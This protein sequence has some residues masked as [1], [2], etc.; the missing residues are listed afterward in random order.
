M[1][2]LLL[3]ALLTGPVSAGDA[4]VAI[5]LL[6]TQGD[7]VSAASAARLDAGLAAALEDLPAFRRVDPGDEVLATMAADPAC[8]ELHSCL[9]PLLSEDVTL[10]LD[11]RLGMQ[12]GQLVLDLRLQHDGRLARRHASAL[13]SSQ[14]EAAVGRELPMLL[15]GWSADA[16][17]Y[18]RA[19]EGDEEAAAA[20]RRHFPG[21]S[22]L[23]ALDQERER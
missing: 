21:S 10:V 20:L 1:H 5:T 19:L 3:A 8:R 2:A 11:P 4:R 15:A 7:G 9:G 13:R 6:P 23:Q 18:A 17:L 22:W 12:D 16:R 14:L